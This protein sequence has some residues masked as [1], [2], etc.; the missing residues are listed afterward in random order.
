MEIMEI[1]KNFIIDVP[2]KEVWSVSGDQFGQA[3]NWATGLYHSEDIGKP[4]IP[5]APSTNRARVTYQG[6]IKE[7]VRVYLETGKP[8]LAKSKELAKRAA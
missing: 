3:C 1:K 4:T 2:T 5:G 7:E 8:S 6:D